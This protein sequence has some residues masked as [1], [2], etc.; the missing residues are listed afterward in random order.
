MIVHLVK[1]THLLKSRRA[2]D[3]DLDQHPADHIDS[4]KTH[5][6]RNKIVPHRLTDLMI[7]LIQCRRLGTP[8]L[9]EIIELNALSVQTQN[10]AQ[11]FTVQQQNTLVALVCGR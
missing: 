1:A 2:G 5:S 6:M 4:S 9:I 10:R 3:I 8:A 11:R 7:T